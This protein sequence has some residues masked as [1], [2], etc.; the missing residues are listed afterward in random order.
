MEPAKIDFSPFFR[1]GAFPD[2]F[3]RLRG[4]SRTRFC[5]D[6]A[7][8]F[9]RFRQDLV[10]SS[11]VPPGCCRD[12]HPTSVT[13]S[14]GFPWGTA[15]SRSDLNSP[16]PVGVLACQ[17][18]AN[19]LPEWEGLP[20]L[21]SPPAPHKTVGPSRGTGA[22]ACFRFVALSALNLSMLGKT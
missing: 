4:P 5:C 21:T 10:G 14:A 12:P 6:F 7:V 1:S 17:T 15:I 16:Y 11:R 22:A 13:H 8:L 20:L 3:R 19:S 2:R 18:Q 9:R